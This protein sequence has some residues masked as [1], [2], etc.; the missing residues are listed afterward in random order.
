MISNTLKY[1]PFFII[2][3]PILINAQIFPKSGDDV[4]SLIP[5]GYNLKDVAFGD[6]NVDSKDDLVIVIRNNSTRKKSVAIYLHNDS[7]WKLE[8]ESADFF[9]LDQADIFDPR[10]TNYG[11]FND[12]NKNEEYV[13]LN[14]DN[15][16]ITINTNDGWGN[17]LEAKFRK[18]KSNQ[19]ILI[20]LITG[21]FYRNNSTENSFNYLTSKM[22]IKTELIGEDLEGKSEAWFKIL[23]A[24]KVNFDQFSA[25]KILAEKRSYEYE[26]LEEPIEN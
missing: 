7:E 5:D 23:N 13:G 17:S 19:Y 4:G 2:L 18:N 9:Y 26:E 21:S 22:Q 14:I 16:V 11:S 15:S 20:G 8:T 10:F 24:K 6:L 1:C 25:K 12:R 3:F